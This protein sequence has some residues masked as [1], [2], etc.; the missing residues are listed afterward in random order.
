MDLV[1]LKNVNC[2]KKFKISFLKN[3]KILIF[4]WRVFFYLKN[5]NLDIMFAENVFP[6]K[7]Y[8]YFQKKND[9]QILKI[10]NF[11]NQYLFKKNFFFKKKNWK[12]YD[13]FFLEIK[14]FF[15]T[16]HYVNFI[17]QRIYKNKKIQKTYLVIYSDDFKFSLSN[18]NYS[19]VDYI[20]DYNKSF[21]RN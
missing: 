13:N 4:D 15:D 7:K 1:I 21:S 17:L 18:K 5:K 6:F 10:I 2:L 16:V 12:F 14:Q 8:N 11:L 9:A 19:A 20:L 3:K